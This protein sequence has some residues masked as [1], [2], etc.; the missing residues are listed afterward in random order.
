M[1]WEPYAANDVATFQ[2]CYGT[3]VPVTAVNV[4]GGPGNNANDVEA[5]MDIQTVIALAPQAQVLVYQG[6]EANTDA[7]WIDVFDQIATDNR[8]DVIST[9]WGSCEAQ[10][11]SYAVKHEATV[12]AQMAAQ[13]QS[14]LASSGDQGSEDCQN[15]NG[16]GSNAL[17][18]DDPGTQPLA[19]SVG[20]TSMQ[21]L[22]PP[23]GEQTW[24]DGISGGSGGGGISANAPMPSWQTG[25][26]VVSPQSSG[27]PCSAPSGTLCRQVPDVSALAGGDTDYLYYWQG[28]WTNEGGTSAST[29]LWAA[30]VA[31]LMSHPTCGGQR[32]G[33]LN[34]KLYAVASTFGASAF[35]DITIG[36]ND[37]GDQHGGLYPATPGYDMA[38]GL[39]TPI[40]GGLLT[41]LCG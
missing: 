17:A 1:E 8:A 36:T 30:M 37:A 29:P 31:T 23:P 32:F 38:T 2:S 19:T 14:F 6:S 22:G 11:D 24:N 39:G 20:G 26:G 13:G 34:P 16:S 33:L 12:L 18:V 9:S 3:S 35:N 28:Q 15:G 4:D 21:A 10:T 25:P 27:A 7:S 5:T 41:G 40:G